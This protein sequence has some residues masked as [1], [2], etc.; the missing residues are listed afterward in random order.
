MEATFSSPK[1]GLLIRIRK[2]SIYELLTHG[3]FDRDVLSL[4]LCL[5]RWS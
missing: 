1:H 2:S 4:P 5:R 3:G